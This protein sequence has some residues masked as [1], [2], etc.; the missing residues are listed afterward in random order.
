MLLGPREERCMFEDEAE[1]TSQIHIVPDAI[2]LF[3]GSS[4]FTNS[5]IGK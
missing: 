2:S 3:L 1:L 4:G 5:A